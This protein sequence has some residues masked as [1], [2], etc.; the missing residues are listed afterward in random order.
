MCDMCVK[1]HQGTSSPQWK[2]YRGPFASDPALENDSA[3]KDGRP[4]RNAKSPGA[5]V[6]ATP[7]N[8]SF[9]TRW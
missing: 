5:H 9:E 2:N 6:L 8:F 7:A 4:V 3:M 1:T